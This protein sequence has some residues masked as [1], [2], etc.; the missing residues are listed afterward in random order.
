MVVHCCG[1]R[2]RENVHLNCRLVLRWC[3]R[4]VLW[5]R[6]WYTSARR[7]CS[8]GAVQTVRKMLKK[9]LSNGGFKSWKTTHLA[10]T[11]CKPCSKFIQYT[12][13]CCCRHCYLLTLKVLQVL[14]RHLQDVG[15]LQLGV[16]CRIFFHG[17]QYQC[18]QLIKTVIDS[19]STPFLHDR[20]ITP[21]IFVRTPLRR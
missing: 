15:L 13:I 4:G 10:G 19:S 5:G 14:H 17:V 20:F 11:L 7:G 12:W 21:S 18:F 6:L 9:S 8:C 1:R 3:R 2:R 16:S